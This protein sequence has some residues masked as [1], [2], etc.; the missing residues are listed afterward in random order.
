[1]VMPAAP[2]APA[3]SEPITAANDTGANKLQLAQQ[4]LQQGEKDLA[5][6][7]LLSAIKSNNPSVQT[8]ALQLLNTLQ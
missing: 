3:A 1:M 2:V 7:L 6:A 8:Q 5:R 4:L